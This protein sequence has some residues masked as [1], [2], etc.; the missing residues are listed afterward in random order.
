MMMYDGVLFVFVRNHVCI[1]KVSPSPSNTKSDN[2]RQKL[3]AV[4][5]HDLAA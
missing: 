2:K 3:R 1:F 4:S 5:A